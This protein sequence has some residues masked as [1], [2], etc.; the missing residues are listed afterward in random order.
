M[1]VVKFFS[2]LNFN[3]NS[4]KKFYLCPYDF[5][6]CRYFDGVLGFSG[7]CVYSKIAGDYFRCQRLPEW[8]LNG[9]H[10]AVLGRGRLHV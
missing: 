8:V 3:F 4:V 5:L 6:S 9:E 2:K 1:L 10:L 7:C